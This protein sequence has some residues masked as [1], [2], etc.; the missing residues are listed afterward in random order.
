M[1]V[2]ALNPAAFEADTRTITPR[3]IPGGLSAF[4]PHD[5]S[6]PAQVLTRWAVNNSEGKIRGSQQR[7]CLQGRPTRRVTS[8]HLSM[9]KDALAAMH[10]EQFALQT[11]AFKEVPTEKADR[12][13]SGNI[14]SWQSALFCDEDTIVSRN[15]GQFTMT[16]LSTRRF[17]EGG[18][19]FIFPTCTPSPDLEISAGPIGVNHYIARISAVS[20][21]VLTLPSTVPAEV[22]PGWSIVPALDCLALDQ[23]PEQVISAGNVRM[24]IQ[25]QEV[26]GMNT[27]PASILAETGTMPARWSQHSNGLYILDLEH[28]FS[29]Q[30]ESG[31]RKHTASAASGLGGHTNQSG[32]KSR[33]YWDLRILSMSRQEFWDVLNFWDWHRGSHSPFWFIFPKLVWEQVSA[34]DTTTIVG[35]RRGART[36]FERNVPALAVYNANH[37]FVVSSISSI[38]ESLGGEWEATLS[39]ALPI[40]FEPSYV[41]PAAVCNFDGDGLGES[42]ITLKHCNLSIG[43]EESLHRADKEFLSAV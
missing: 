30:A 28:D 16:D 37:E 13:E 6:S 42:W 34:P 14:A 31:F 26:S 41:R 36:L 21:N 9:G 23:I 40:G 10:Q 38:T 3:P 1:P 35:H 20:G 15:A 19:V 24:E 25:A 22:G 4:A 5:W 17:F 29:S 12:L 18:L 8:N 11:Q 43:I 27:I 7:Y 33:R 39:D 2:R 32:S